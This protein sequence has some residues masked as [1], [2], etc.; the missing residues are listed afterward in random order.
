MSSV[1]AAGDDGFEFTND[2]FKPAQRR[3]WIQLFDFTKASRILEVGSYEG[4]SACF[5]IE[6]LGGRGPIELHCV[7]TWE[8]GVEHKKVQTPMGEVEARFDRNVARAIAAAAHPVR[9]FKHKGASMLWMSRLIAGGL[10]GQ[11]EFIYV[12]GSH[13]APDVLADAVLAFELLKV[14]GVMVFDDYLWAE[15]MPYGLDPLRCPKPAVDAFVNL[16]FRRC[17]LLQAPLYQ[18]YIKKTAA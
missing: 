12:D 17:R 8:G 6:H 11:F 14:G 7:D 13:Q 3:E 1:T 15:I 5:L 2:W 16:N 10:S 9:F 4:A 18:A